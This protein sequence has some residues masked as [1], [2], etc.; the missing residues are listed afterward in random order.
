MTVTHPP[1]SYNFIPQRPMGAG[2]YTLV[3]ESMVLHAIYKGTAT[4]FPQNGF[5]NHYKS[6]V[7]SGDIKFTPA[8]H[9]FVYKNYTLTDKGKLRLVTEK[10][11]E[12]A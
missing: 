8:Q 9:P 5:L 4:T 7:K 1:L 11:M 12:G 2:S 3:T 6:L 10:M